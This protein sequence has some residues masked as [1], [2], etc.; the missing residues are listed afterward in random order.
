MLSCCAD[1]VAPVL[2]DKAMTVLKTEPMFV[3]MFTNAVGVLLVGVTSSVTGE[4]VQA[5][6][7]FTEE[8]VYAYCG[9]V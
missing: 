1:A 4:A 3:M 5:Y 2:Q 9:N 7:S 6:K 8:P